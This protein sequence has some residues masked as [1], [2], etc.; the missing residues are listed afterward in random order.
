MK[1]KFMLMI[2][3]A[4]GISIYMGITS[5]SKNK[6]KIKCKVNSLIDDTASMFN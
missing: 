6:N 1:D 2:G 3:A 5:L 4:A